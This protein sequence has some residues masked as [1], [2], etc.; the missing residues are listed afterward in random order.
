MN[1]KHF[2]IERKTISNEQLSYNG[3]TN[4]NFFDQSIAE[5]NICQQHHENLHSKI[6]GLYYSY[7]SIK[8]QNMGRILG[9]RL[10]AINTLFLFL[11]VENIHL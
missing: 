9:F 6:E 2:K 5:Q 8:T 1:P 3:L 11:I 7:F 10:A 4:I